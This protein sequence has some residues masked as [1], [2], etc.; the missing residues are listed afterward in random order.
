MAVQLEVANLYV[1]GLRLKMRFEILTESVEEDSGIS[2]TTL[3]KCKFTI[4][5]FEI[6]LFAS[7][8][9]RNSNFAD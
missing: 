5:L 1:E 3:Q 6:S 8:K 4:R 9:V 2:R 7:F